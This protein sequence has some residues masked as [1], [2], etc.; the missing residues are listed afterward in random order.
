MCQDFIYNPFCKCNTFFTCLPLSLF[1]FGFELKLH[2]QSLE[3]CFINDLTPF[4]RVIKLNTLTFTSFD[5][6]RTHFFSRRYVINN[7]THSTAFIQTNH[8]WIIRSAG[9]KLIR[10]DLIINGLL[11]KEKNLVADDPLR[12][13]NA[14]NTCFIN[15]KIVLFCVHSLDIYEYLKQYQL[16]NHIPIHTIK[17]CSY[18]QLRKLLKHFPNTKELLL[19]LLLVL[20]LQ[21]LRLN[22][23]FL[24]DQKYQNAS[25]NPILLFSTV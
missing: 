18:H 2:L 10:V 15:P 21:V 25:A 17:F 11:F 4:I 24:R 23:N 19:I 20:M 14:I 16:K 12:L 8:E 6:L 9:F 1:N 5:S 22:Q 13:I 7:I 3:I